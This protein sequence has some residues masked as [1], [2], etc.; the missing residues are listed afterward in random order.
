MSNEQLDMVERFL[1]VFFFGK[2]IIF[3]KN[4]LKNQKEQEFQENLFFLEKFKSPIQTTYHWAIWALVSS[5]LMVFCS[6][7]MSSS[8]VPWVLVEFS[9][10]SFSLFAPLVCAS[11]S[12]K[13]E[14]SI[15]VAFGAGLSES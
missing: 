13:F 8:Q 15:S 6:S 4:T 12:D 3:V 14:L 10:I 11:H 7:S 1:V 5:S 2:V 9:D